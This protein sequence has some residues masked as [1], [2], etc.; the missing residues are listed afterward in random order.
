MNGECGEKTENP[1]ED[2]P[3]QNEA[4]DCW[5]RGAGMKEHR[6]SGNWKHVL[7]TEKFKGVSSKEKG[8][9]RETLRPSG[10][11]KEERRGK[12]S[13]SVTATKGCLNT[14]VNPLSFYWDRL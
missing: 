1:R 2:R 12:L 6:L 8:G 3:E 4:V 13:S 14:T 10:K 11:G 7:L 5:K 9:D